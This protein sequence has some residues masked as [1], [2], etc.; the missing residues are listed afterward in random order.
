MLGSVSGDARRSSRAHGT[1]LRAVLVTCGSLALLTLGRWLC[2]T[3]PP[4][5]PAAP[6]PPPRPPSPPVTTAA[7]D[8]GVSAAAVAA[9]LCEPPPGAPWAAAVAGSVERYGGA[10]GTALM[11]EALPAA[12]ARA[13]WAAAHMAGALPPGWLLLL[14]LPRAARDALLDAD[15]AV[16]AAVCTGKTQLWEL[17]ADNWHD[18]TRVC[19]GPSNGSGGWRVMRVLR[20]E[21][22]L[23][24][25]ASFQGERDCKP[26]VRCGFAN[27][28]QAHPMTLA[29]IPTE[30]Y[31]I[32]QPDG[33]LCGP[34]PA[35]ALAVF[36]GADY[37]GA[38]WANQPVE[39]RP[40]YTD[41]AAFVGGNGGFSLRTKSVILRVLE[42]YAA[43]WT[44]DSWED[45]F[46]SHRVERVGGRLPSHALAS[47]FSIEAVPYHGPV[48]GVH[49]TWLHLAMKDD[50]WNIAKTPAAI[51]ALASLHA[52]C[53]VL[54][55]LM[56]ANGVN[57]VFPEGYFV[58]P[59]AAY[60][61][62]TAGFYVKPA[63]SKL[64]RNHV[65]APPL[66]VMA[67]AP[68]E[69]AAPPAPAVPNAP[70]SSDAAA[71]VLRPDLRRAE[72]E[73]LDFNAV[74]A[75]EVSDKAANPHFTHWTPHNF[76]DTY[77]R[78]LSRFRARPLTMLEIGLGCKMPAGP[79]R[80]IPLWRRYVPCA[81]LHVLEFDGDCAEP[82]RAALEGLYIGDQSSAAV[83][84]A[85]LHGPGVPYDVV[86]DD[87][88]H[89][90]PHQIASFSRLFPALA[91][92]GVYFIED[93][94]C[95]FD[96][97][98]AASD[99]PALLFIAALAVRIALRDVRGPLSVL[100][101]AATILQWA[102]EA[103]ALADLVDHIG[104]GPAICAIVRNN[105]PVP[106]RPLSGLLSSK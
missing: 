17:P 93:L 3:A 69:S 50:A 25:P 2:A 80:S 59:T 90:S 46:F 48:L 65:A 44:S 43:E 18:L 101:E 12:A 37:I 32:F 22:L 27:E 86:V 67:A 76:G 103:D 29:A 71:C 30:R 74:V 1:L 57:Y 91:P 47:S 79:G 38:P 51:A 104:C 92:G 9:C 97:W 83:L 88:S 96:D 64:G 13:A 45:S 15:A 63:E 75:T 73:V 62:P 26:Y 33:V 11:A 19:P 70:R 105:K 10:V 53:P 56:A 58:G 100:G 40:V 4:P 42:K 5:T 66:L 14:I 21:G 7:L 23:A 6:P 77:E 20:A 54:P 34:T 39:A 8:G 81:R 95:G 16:R 72:D 82:F 106:S 98:C 87:G 24:T 55:H 31:L 41:P 102:T 84:D 61:R 52:S 78:Y 68:T 89:M 36:D 85:A 99:R 28:V 94:H 60:T 49:K 35:S